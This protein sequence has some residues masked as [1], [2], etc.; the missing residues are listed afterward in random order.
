M[1]VEVWTQE[2]R[3]ARVNVSKLRTDKH[4]CEEWLGLD[5][6][7][8]DG[9]YYD[10]GICGEVAVYRCNACRKYFCLEC[11][12]FHLH[13]TVVERSTISEL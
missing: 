6:N 9:C 1:G 3:E 4:K 5:S 8:I 12:E 2:S 13:M 10:R 11:W 7:S